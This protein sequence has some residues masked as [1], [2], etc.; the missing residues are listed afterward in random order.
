M[1]ICRFVSKNTKDIYVLATL[2]NW[3][4]SPVTFPSLHKIIPGEISSRVGRVLLPKF[5]RTYSD[6]NRQ[7]D[8]AIRTVN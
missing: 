8:N 4:V 7:H 3:L 1:G 5:T 6:D 2:F